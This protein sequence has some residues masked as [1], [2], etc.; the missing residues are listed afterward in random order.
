MIPFTSSIVQVIQLSYQYSLRLGYV[1]CWLPWLEDDGRRTETHI[2]N[3]QIA[4]PFDTEAIILKFY[5]MP[6]VGT[7]YYSID[8]VIQI[9]YCDKNVLKGCRYRSQNRLVVYI[10]NRALWTKYCHQFEFFVSFFLNILLILVRLVCVPTSSY[11]LSY[12][13]NFTKINLFFFF[14]N[15]FPFIKT[16]LSITKSIKK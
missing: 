10:I 11:S 12:S 14:C 1:S 6:Q 9:S 3:E 4:N 7:T 8:R 15:A 2:S 5:I 16:N 13:K